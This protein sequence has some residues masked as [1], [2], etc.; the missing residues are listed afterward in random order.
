MP[1]LAWSVIIFCG[2]LRAPPT[3]VCT[4]AG[5][6]A[7]GEAKLRQRQ[8]AVPSHFFFRSFLLRL[9]T[10][11]IATQKH[12]F[13][14]GQQAAGEAGG[15]AA[16]AA[17][18]GGGAG[19]SAARNAAGDLFRVRRPGRAA[20][21]APRHA[22]RQRQLR[23]RVATHQHRVGVASRP[24][25]RQP[26]RCVIR[27]T[28]MAAAHGCPHLPTAHVCPACK[29][30]ERALLFRP[31]SCAVPLW[32]CMPCCAAPCKSHHLTD[33][34]HCLHHVSNGAPAHQLCPRLVHL[35]VRRHS[36]V[37]ATSLLPS[38]LLHHSIIS[39]RGPHRPCHHAAG[40]E[41]PRSARVPESPRPDGAAIAERRIAELRALL[42]M[43]QSKT[44]DANTKV[45]MLGNECI[46]K[47]SQGRERNT[48]E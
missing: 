18:G 26:Q 46:E 30:N 23:P 38:M 12:P 36:H 44:E 48:V 14:S 42:T 17:G 1:E 45:R 9:M 40:M 15:E 47:H 29:P 22:P 41:T 2:G 33:P 39:T 16:A 5:Q 28:L 20:A 4:I 31:A 35:K 27:C 25:C 32:L 8:A 21:L 7:A 43:Q 11:C 24:A 19:A 10:A 3:V 34:E 13:R 6:Q 37:T